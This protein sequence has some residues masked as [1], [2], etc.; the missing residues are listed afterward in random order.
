[1]SGKQ[2]DLFS[3]TADLVE[4][5]PASN[6][7]RPDIAYDTLDNDS[8]IA[9]LPHA[10]I[11][12]SLALA[13]EAGR[14]RLPEAIPALEALCRRFAGFGIDR[15]VP[16]QAAAL[17]AL[18]LIGGIGAAQAVTRLISKRIV[19]GP[20]LSTAV[21]AAAQLGAKLPADAVL[22]LLQHRDA[23]V[24]ADAC[25]CTRPWPEV[26]PLLID[27]M[28]DLRSAVRT[29]A[30]C[31]LGRMGR[32]EAR[33]LLAR[34]LREEPSAELIDAIAPVADEECIV[35]LG[36]VARAVPDLLSAALD[37]LESIDHP[38]AEKIAMAI[39][40]ARRDELQFADNAQR[41]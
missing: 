2:L 37:A 8:L 3:A 41:L 17:N 39:G 13:A 20:V 18:V 19:Q 9:A 30:A 11:R 27:L 40:G 32:S 26:F 14:R 28:D 25:R 6:E 5:V 16:E 15:I 31:A 36:Q 33:P 29:A 22:G 35:L 38:R 34:R 7:T 1:V 24:R 12:D 23:Q 10:G 21:A 4:R